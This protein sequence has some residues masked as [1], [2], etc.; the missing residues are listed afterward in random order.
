MGCACRGRNRA[1]G[2]TSSGATIAG[3][4]YT[5]PTGEVKVFLTKIEA[6]AE[7]RRNGGGTI[8]QLTSGA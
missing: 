1:G 5:S 2:K 4:R 8:L 3:Y 6:V 7:Q